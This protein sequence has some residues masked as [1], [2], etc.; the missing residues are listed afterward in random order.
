MAIVEIMTF[1]VEHYM[2]TIN[3]GG[4]PIVILNMIGAGIIIIIICIS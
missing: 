1:V 2:K 4:S 3:G